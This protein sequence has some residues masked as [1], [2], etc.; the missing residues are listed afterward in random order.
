MTLEQLKK[1]VDSTIERNEENKDLDVC[2]PNNKPQ[3]GPIG[4]THVKGAHQGTDWNKSKF[5]LFPENNM[6]E[7]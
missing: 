5:I 2:I 7:Q 6:I 3:M 4:V 1:I